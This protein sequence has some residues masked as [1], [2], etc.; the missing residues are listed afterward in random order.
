MV[1]KGGIKKEV[2]HNWFRGWPDFGVPEDKDEIE[3][4]TE[5]IKRFDSFVSNDAETGRSLIHCRAGW[6]RSGTLLTIIS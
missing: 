4:F 3:G 1:E 5:L 6:G 2:T